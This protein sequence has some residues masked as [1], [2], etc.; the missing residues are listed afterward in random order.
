MAPRK[1]LVLAL[2]DGSTR[3]FDLEA[4][5]EYVLGR[6]VEGQPT[7]S[8]PLLAM[9]AS[10]KHAKIELRPDGMFVQDLK[11]MHGT[12]LDSHRLEPLV[13]YLWKEGAILRFGID[14]GAAGSETAKHMTRGKLGAEAAKGYGVKRSWSEATTQQSVAGSRSLEEGAGNGSS[15]G[16]LS[17]KSRRTAFGAQPAVAPSER[18]AA[19]AAT[20]GA[21]RHDQPRGKS[22]EPIKSA[23]GRFIGPML[24][25]GTANGKAVPASTGRPA[26]TKKCDKCDGPHPTDDCPHFKKAR[27]VH[28]DAWVNYGQKKPIQMGTPCGS[29]FLR[30]AQI[31]R[32][33]GDGSCMFHSLCFGLGWRGGAWQLRQ[34]LASFVGANPKVEIGG[35]SLE[36]WVRWDSNITCKAYANRMSRGGW[37][38]AIEMATCSLVKKVNVHVYERKGGGF[39]RIT[40][41]DHP[42]AKKTLHILYQGRAHYDALLVQ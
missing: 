40:C 12:Y 22:A 36:E 19:A 42:G 41:F 39:Q 34:Q 17:N 13:P 32:Q 3:T 26:A 20:A 18:S 1:T 16:E 8:I 23:A 37:G 25:P 15:G 10:R 4:K 14:H 9:S 11:S 30:H 33:P 35:D 28:K 24:P 7:P 31:I 21:V 2:M 38:G 29:L 27:E 6:E 5:T